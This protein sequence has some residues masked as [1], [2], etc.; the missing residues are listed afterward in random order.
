MARAENSARPL[1]SE[2]ALPTFLHP[3]PRLT[4][5][6]TGRPTLRGLTV[7]VRA[8]R[9]ESG[10][11]V[12]R[13]CWTICG[14]TWRLAR[15]RVALSAADDAA[16]GA[17]VEGPATDPVWVARSRDA[18]ISSARALP[19]S[20]RR[21]GMAVSL[22]RGREV[23]VFT[24]I[25][26]RVSRTPQQPKSSDRS[27]GSSSCGPAAGGRRLGGVRADRVARAAGHG[28]LIDGQPASNRPG[29]PPHPRGVAAHGAIER[30]SYLV[31]RGT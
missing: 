23:L 28:H 24:G 1:R 14:I 15:D 31:G 5:S 30:R 10:L 20:T 2:R 9:A 12:R 27:D 17:I 4:W 11:A 18:G 6:R 16:M 21:A 8:T 7:A 22:C 3:E 13:P 25:H 29:G 19:A 26:S